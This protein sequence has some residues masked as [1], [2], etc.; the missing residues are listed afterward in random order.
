M[1]HISLVLYDL[2]I[3]DILL[4]WK[5]RPSTKIGHQNRIKSPWIPGNLSALLRTF[6]SWR[7]VTVLLFGDV[8]MCVE[9]SF[10]SVFLLHQK[11]GLGR[12]ERGFAVKVGTWLLGMV[13]RNLTAMRYLEIL[14][15][16]SFYVIGCAISYF[17]PQAAVEM[18]LSIVSKCFALLRSDPHGRLWLDF[19]EKYWEI[20]G[21]VLTPKSEAQWL[22]HISEWN[23]ED[24]VDCRPLS[25][26]SFLRCFSYIASALKNTLY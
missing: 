16:E 17:G 2:M 14:R 25:W 9:G 5:I 23:I 3:F 19:T 24:V 21:D 8:Y 4:Y 6:W 13:F 18:T 22:S 26:A 11:P 1:T 12:I 15:K 10:S 7:L 20:E